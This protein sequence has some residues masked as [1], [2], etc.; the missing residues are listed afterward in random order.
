MS[1]KRQRPRLPSG[2]H[3]PPED[4]KPS[5]TV[6]STSSPQPAPFFLNLSTP[7]HAGLT[8]TWGFALD[9]IFAQLL[10]LRQLRLPHRG[11]EGPDEHVAL[12]SDGQCAAPPI[13]STLGSTNTPW[14]KLRRCLRPTWA[15]CAAKRG[16][17]SRSRVIQ[18]L[19]VS[20]R[21]TAKPQAWKARACEREEEESERGCERRVGKL[22]VARNARH[23]TLSTSEDD[24]D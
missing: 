22:D 23:G 10:R 6:H 24:S 3:R 21:Y 17:A 12:L 13:R 1:Q 9:V 7:L 2:A 20:W 15:S 8:S 5:I 16:R 18:P 4:A 14:T 11:T 19:K